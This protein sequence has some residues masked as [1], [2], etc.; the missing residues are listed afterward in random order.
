M[1]GGVPDGLNAG[2]SCS[3][4]YYFRSICGHVADY[5]VSWTASLEYVVVHHVLPRSCWSAVAAV[6]C[7]GFVLFRFNP[8]RSCT[9]QSA[10]HT[11]VK[12]L[13][14]FII[15]RIYARAPTE[16]SF[17]RLHL[18]LK[19]SSHDHDDRRYIL[20]DFKTSICWDDVSLSTVL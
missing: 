17:T 20:F 14:A 5:I 4:Y 2:V 8:L 7:C 9:T 13:S 3:S 15:S 18:G 11:S 6:C 10:W 12:C 1:S 19:L 16:A